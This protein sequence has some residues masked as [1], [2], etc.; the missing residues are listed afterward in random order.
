MG[1]Q[2]SSGLPVSGLEFIK[3]L[4]NKFLPNVLDASFYVLPALLAFQNQLRDE[5]HEE[6]YDTVEFYLSMGS[7]AF[8]MT[9][10]SFDLLRKLDG[11]HQIQTAPHVHVEGSARDVENGGTAPLISRSTKLPFATALK[12][13][14]SEYYSVDTLRNWLEGAEHEREELI[15][16]ANN[17]IANKVSSEDSQ[18]P[19]E[20]VEKIRNKIEQLSQQ[21]IE[22]SF[23]VLRLKLA[24]KENKEKS[25]VDKI[26]HIGNLFALSTTFA[27]RLGLAGLNTVATAISNKSKFFDHVVTAVQ[28]IVQV[29]I[30]TIPLVNQLSSHQVTFSGDELEALKLLDPKIDEA[31]VALNN[32]ISL[33]NSKEQAQQ[34]VSSGSPTASSSHFPTRRTRSTNEESKPLIKN[35]KPGRSSSV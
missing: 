28:S 35:E 25:L 20:D 22:K 18:V 8:G 4:V 17:L 31:I 1:T 10:V 30:P 23:A 5:A 33:L 12:V 11:I 14:C 6:W 16:K 26:M 9:H 7:L 34:T 27:S 13:S 19:Q 29:G 32:Q 24:H 21:Y 3:L 2:P 15:K